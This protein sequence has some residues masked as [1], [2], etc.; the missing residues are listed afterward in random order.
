MANRTRAATSLGKLGILTKK[1]A[2]DGS[3]GSKNGLALFS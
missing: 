2:R 1:Y 3:F